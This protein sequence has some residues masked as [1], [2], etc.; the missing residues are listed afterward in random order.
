MPTAML[1]QLLDREG[2]RYITIQHS[3]AYTAQEVAA[4]AHVSGKEMAK[5]VVT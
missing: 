2:I 1:T 5:T 3:R 4:A